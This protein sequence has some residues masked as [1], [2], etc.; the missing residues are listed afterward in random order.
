[1]IAREPV[2]AVQ[3]PDWV[4]DE[5][6]P[7]TSRYVEV[8]GCRVHYI[9]E[10]TGPVLL[11]LHGNPTWSFLYRHL[12]PALRD[13]FRCIALDYPGF[14]LSTAA[15]GYGYTPAEHAAVVTEFITALNLEAFTPFCQDW[16]G[17]IGLAV[18]ARHPDRVQAV[19]IGN[20]F[21]WPVAGDWHFEWF[22]RLFGGALG[23]V[24]V[25]R[26]NA[27]VNVLVPMGTRQRRLTREEMDHYRRPLAT[28]TAREPTWVLPR[29]IRRSG[30]FLAEVEAGLQR[31]RD[32]PALIVWGDR[33][34]AFRPV[35]RCRFEQLFPRHTLVDLPGAG[36][37]IQEDA[38]DQI[39]EAVHTWWDEHQAST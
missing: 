8:A 27:V 9:D 12:V 3:R 7:F 10:G 17:P 24:A 37:Y 31:L 33:D 11:L 29:E 39:A 28:P 4:D 1:M 30:A 2:D 16:G 20:T 5:L 21:A 34:I 36:H 38:P 22:S 15:R 6:F 23:R 25:R 32:V 18:A 13:R 19:I 26:L 14:G 35:E